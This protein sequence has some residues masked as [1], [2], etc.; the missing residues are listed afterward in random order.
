M[1]LRSTILTAILLSPSALLAAEQGADKTTTFTAPSV[2]GSLLWETLLFLLLIIGLIVGLGWLLR[3][4][5]HAPMGGKG[6]VTVLGSVSLGTRE[7][8]VVLQSGDTRLLVGVAPGQ[9][10]MLCMLESSGEKGTTDDNGEFARK[11]DTAV[12]EGGSA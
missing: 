2:G 7:R 8:A 3:R 5:G 1:I 10:Q 9:V 12:D 11:L 6:M 4:M